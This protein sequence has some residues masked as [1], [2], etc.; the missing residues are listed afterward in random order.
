MKSDHRHELKTNVLADWMTHIPEW[1]HKNAKPLIGGTALVVLV[2]VAVFWS[3]YNNTVLAHTHR[4]QFTSD[5]ADLE[6]RTMQVAQSHAQGED[7]SIT[8]GESSSSLGQLAENTSSPVMAAM[9][10]IKQAEMLRE[11]TNFENAQPTE[12]IRKAR[13]EAARTAYKVALEKGQ[14]NKTLVSVAQYGLGLCAEELGQFDEAA[15]IYQA[16]ISDKAVDGTIGQAAAGHRI[17]SMT[18]FQGLITFPIVEE[19]P[20]IAAPAPQ[21]EIG[22]MLPEVP[23]TVVAPNDTPAEVNG[24]E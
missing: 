5:L 1:S 11:Q 8:L 7:M 22:P 21:P 9:A 18:N 19:T 14:T 23:A 10:Y 20:E 24:T 4:V 6:A 12:E 13:V 3:Q 16:L 15:N 2:A 17:K